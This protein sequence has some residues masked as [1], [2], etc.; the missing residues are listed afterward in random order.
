MALCSKAHKAQSGSLQTGQSPRQQDLGRCWC[1]ED[2]QGSGFESQFLHLQGTVLTSQRTEVS[3]MS[4]D[5]IP[6]ETLSKWSPVFP[7]CFSLS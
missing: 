4:T 6:E 7:L 5:I 1:H 2:R 3:S